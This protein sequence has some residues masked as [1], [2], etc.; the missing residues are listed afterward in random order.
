V[1]LTPNF[2][3]SFFGMLGGEIDR[4]RQSGKAMEWLRFVVL[5]LAAYFVYSSNRTTQVRLLPR[6]L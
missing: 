1:T 5:L 6:W 4:R 3:A 2:P